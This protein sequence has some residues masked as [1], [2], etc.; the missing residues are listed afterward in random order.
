M[1][2]DAS[3]SEPNPNTSTHLAMT[4]EL[5]KPNSVNENALSE[6]EVLRLELHEDVPTMNRKNVVREKVQ[7][8]KFLAQQASESNQ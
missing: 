5:N 3:P 1:D 4:D 7:I 8:R 6:G 2:Y